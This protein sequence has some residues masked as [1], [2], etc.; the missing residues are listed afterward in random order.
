MKID[1]VLPF[2]LFLIT[3]AVSLLYV[4]FEGKMKSLLGGKELRLRD[5]ALLVVAMG[6][7]VTIL[8]FIPGMAILALF[9]FIYSLVL[10]T[11]TYLV[12]PR[13]Y[14]AVLPPALFI[15]LYLYPNLWNLYWLNLFAVVF[16]VFV[17]VYLGSLFTW[18]TT[19]VFA[20]LLTIMDIVQVFGTKFMVVSSEKMIGLLL[21][22]MVILPTFPSEGWIILGLGDIFLSGLLVIQTTQKYG[23]KFGIVSTIS[24]ASFF[25]LLETILLNYIVRYF[26][27]TA[28]VICGWLTALG[29]RYLYQSL[30]F[31]TG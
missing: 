16:A 11:F 24:I 22:T 10:F 27:A 12:T 28:M 31:E 1:V 9:L 4:K 23:R 7:T 13:W 20:A 19:A 18:K 3:T 14:V 15:F 29:V 8:V 30:V 21:P 25:L 26:P 2:T 5:A 6:F 17:S